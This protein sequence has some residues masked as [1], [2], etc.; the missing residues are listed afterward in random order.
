MAKIINCDP[1]T[2]RKYFRDE[3][4]ANVEIVNCLYESAKGGNVTAQIFFLKTR[5]QWRECRAMENSNPG[6]RV[7]LTPTMVLLPDNYRDPELTEEIRKA[8]ER[9]F[10][11]KQRGQRLK[12]SISDSHR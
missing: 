3:L 2:L 10:A 6:T 8:Q 1:K 12:K 5:A 9:Y 11:K 4:E 7:G